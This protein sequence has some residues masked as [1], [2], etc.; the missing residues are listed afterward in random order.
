[1]VIGQ[2]QALATLTTNTSAHITLQARG[3][4]EHTD[5]L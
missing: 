4:P 5:T 2:I 1:M 3:V